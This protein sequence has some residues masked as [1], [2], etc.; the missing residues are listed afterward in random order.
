V[1]SINTWWLDEMKTLRDDF[2]N[3]LEK[4]IDI[5]L[6]RDDPFDIKFDRVDI[7]RD[8]WERDRDGITFGFW[9]E[10]KSKDGTVIQ[11]SCFIEMIDIDYYREDD[12]DDAKELKKLLKSKLHMECVVGFLEEGGMYLEAERDLR[13]TNTKL[14]YGDIYGD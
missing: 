13:I 6:K 3:E 12:P 8:S 5:S 11:G 4:I 14:T 10:S 1:L 7:P 9:A 2:S